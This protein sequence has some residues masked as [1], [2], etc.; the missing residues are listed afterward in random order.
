MNLFKQRIVRYTFN[1]KRR[2]PD[3]HAVT[4]KTPGAVRHVTESAK[5]YAVIG[6]K[7]V[8]LAESKETAKRLYR[9]KTGDQA[10]AAVLPYAGRQQSAM[11]DQIERPLT[12]HLADF[13]K[14]LE[15]ENNCPDHIGRTVGRIQAILDGCRF[16][17]WEDLSAEAVLSWLAQQR[18][19]TRQKDRYG[20]GLVTTNHYITAIKGFSRWLAGG[21]NGHGNGDKPRVPVD[22]LFGLK[23]LSAEGDVRIER[24]ELND[25]DF[26]AFLKATRTGP[27]RRGLAG[28]ERHVLYVVAAYTGLRV[29]ELATLLPGSFQLDADP[30]TVKVKG[31]YTKNKKP[32]ELPLHSS[33]VGLLR[34]F[35]LGKDPK[36]TLV[37]RQSRCSLGELAQARRRDGGGRPGSGRA[38]V[39]GRCRPG[40]RF[41]FASP[42]VHHGAGP[43]RRRLTNG[44]ETGP[45][46]DPCTHC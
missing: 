13:R 19:E 4:S 24:R 28:P 21:R 37:A 18:Q 9:I 42:P 44:A 15:A 11:K 36:G 10:V 33:I 31:S 6:G 43:G 22:A 1:G 8:P 17:R 45:A 32:A 5:W 40:V 34:D 26:A 12:E 16:R 30:P 46:F 2:T 7:H 39:P 14:R 23:K 35:I 3:G 41:P 38:G 25:K 27:V 20:F 29:S